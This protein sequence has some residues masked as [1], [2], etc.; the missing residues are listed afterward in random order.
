MFYFLIGLSLL[1]SLFVGIQGDKR[2]IGF[3]LSF[4]ISVFFTPII[5][6]LFV[7]ASPEDRS[8]GTK[9]LKNYSGPSGEAKQLYDSAMESY[10]N[11]NYSNAINI[12]ERANALQPNNPVVLIGLAHNYANLNNI[13]ETLDYMERAI[14]SGY[15]N[16]KRIQSHDDFSN[17][18]NTERFKKFVKNGYKTRKSQDN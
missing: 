8:R 18:K 11:E 2:E 10:R 13:D 14:E 9:P 16:Y 6:L 3:F 4:I 15:D 7:I 5:G 1:L 17:I 12:L